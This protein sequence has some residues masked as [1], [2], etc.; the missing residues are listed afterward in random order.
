MWVIS[1]RR[2]FVIFKQKCRLSL[3]VWR[4]HMCVCMRAWA[5]REREQGDRAA[6]ALTSQQFRSCY[7]KAIVKMKHRIRA[8]AALHHLWPPHAAETTSTVSGCVREQHL[9]A[10][11]AGA[12]AHW[13]RPNFFQGPIKTQAGQS[14]RL[15]IRKSTQTGKQGISL[16]PW[17][18]LWRYSPYLKK[19]IKKNPI[20]GLSTHL[21]FIFTMKIKGDVFTIFWA[22]ENQEWDN[23]NKICELL[24][25]GMLMTNRNTNQ[26]ILW[27]QL[28]DQ[29]WPVLRI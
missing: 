17:W 2:Y 10:A 24:Q 6:E 22:E 3:F 12:R 25:S 29:F 5:Q 14:R 23:M 21:N 4:L 11:C 7:T 16:A 9:S 28:A 1:G 27:P 8:S 13:L 18:C 15:H 20:C 19:K 26:L